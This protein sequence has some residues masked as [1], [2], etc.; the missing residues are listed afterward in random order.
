MGGVIDME[1]ARSL[2]AD[3]GL[4]PRVRDFLWDFVPQMHPSWIEGLGTDIAGLESLPRVKSYIQNSLNVEPCFH[5]FPREDGSRILL[6]DGAVLESIC[7]WLGALACADA[8]RRVTDGA[9]VRNLKTA[10]NGIY[11]DVFAYVAY[12][13]ALKAEA[14]SCADAG[15]V[16]AAGLELLFAC[17]ADLPEPLSRRLKFKLPKSFCGGEDGLAVPSSGEDKGTAARMRANSLFKLLKLKFPE[18]FA[19]CC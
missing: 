4:W 3:A 12:F 18:A 17:L 2:V 1:G 9:L 13:P 6:L 11:P 7:K 10:L 8:L 16:A 5:A 19:L 15:A 14:R